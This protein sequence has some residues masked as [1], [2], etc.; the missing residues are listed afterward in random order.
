MSWL[1]FGLIALAITGSHSCLKCSQNAMVVLREFKDNY[2]E[3][4]LHRN[5]ELRTKLRSLL[6]DAIEMLSLQPKDPKKF[7]G[8]IDEITLEKLTAYFKRSVNQ[9][10]ENNFKDEQLYNEVMWN[11]QSWLNKFEEIMPKF[12]KIYCSN[13]CGRMLY[14]LINCY[15]CETNYYSCYKDIRCGERRI[16]VEMDEDLIL[17]CA[18]RWHKLSHGVKRYNFY[19]MVNGKPQLMANSLDPFLVKKEANVNDT[20]RYQCEMLDP[21]G[22]PASRLNFQVVVLPSVRRTTWFPRPHATMEGPL[23]LGISSRAPPPQEDWTVWIVIGSTGAL[24]FLIVVT[25]LCYYRRKNDNED[26]EEDDDESESKSSELA[27]M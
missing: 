7:M 23:V 22:H 24:L 5:L 2:L 14:V 10:M 18:L 15:S 12:T 20:G 16:R 9:I 27:E 25:F 4:K 3:T 1:V 6:D 19:R 17:D 13:E 21:E 11:S 26:E 8:V